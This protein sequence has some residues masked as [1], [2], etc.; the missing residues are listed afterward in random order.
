MAFYSLTPI[1]DLEIVSS[2]DV[3]THYRNETNDPYFHV[4]LSKNLTMGWYEIEVSIKCVKGSIKRSKI[5]FDL[6]EGYE[7]SLSI[8]IPEIK[9]NKITAIV[10]FPAEVKG[11]RLDPTIALSEFVIEKIKITKLSQLGATKKLFVVL[12]NK[13]K[14][15]TLPFL[16]KA[17]TRSGISG[18]REE[19]R[20]ANFFQAYADDNFENLSYEQWLAKEISISRLA[21]ENK[22]I[23]KN[24]SYN[25]PLISIVV[26]TY[27]TP[28]KWLNECIQSVIDQ[29]YK[30]WE[31]C[32]SD[33]ASTNTAVK[34]VLKNY[35]EKDPRIKVFFR[36]T[37]GYISTSTN[38]ALE[39]V[40]GEWVAFLDHDDT[41]TENAL[42]EMVS[43]L[44]EKPDLDVIYSDQD[45][46]KED[47]TYYQPFFKPDWSPVF[48][49]GV[50][51]VGHLLIVKNSVGKK[52]GWFNAKF[53]KVQDYELLLR[54]NEITNR[55]GH[56]PKVLYHWRESRGS[57]AFT[58]DAKGKIEELQELAVNQHL[59]RLKIQGIASQNKFPHRLSLHPTKRKYYD[60]ISIIIP[61]KNCASL[62][63]NCI[64]SILEK[65]IYPNYEIVIIDTGSTEQDAM[66]LLEAFDKQEKVNVYH[67]KEKFNFS[68]VNNFGV[69]KATG[70]YFVFLN[71]DTEVITK[72][73]LD[74]M[75]FFA[76]LKQV[77]AV[78]SLLLFPNK[79]VQHAGIV[80]G[81]RGTADHIMRYFP[82]DSD[83]Y[84]GSLSCSREVSAVTA[85]CLMIKKELFLKVGGFEGSYDSVYQD[86]DLCLKIRSKGYS[87]ILATSSV[88]FHHESVSRGNDYNFIDRM[89]LKDQ[90]ETE[91][92]ADPYYNT[93]FKLDVYGQG[94]NGYEPK[95]KVV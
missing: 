68:R 46:I 76:G 42:F 65:T 13:A 34:A 1:H 78:G 70:D 48:F 49:N 10:A 11:L 71:N 8:P 2:S 79:A 5:Y 38:S 53:D 37:N 18:V 39:F 55:I 56:I 57:I 41:L 95:Y 32:I 20:N 59:K 86:V 62:L 91:L 16:F 3:S 4:N 29:T 82:W 33:D 88:L 77:G 43:L 64:E 74:N 92:L 19:L 66:K 94:Y 51:Y 60:K 12:K 87:I 85:A 47:G 26:S 9:D 61:T 63:K 24:G 30:N 89:L 7:E 23:L 81:F 21:F 50:M 31:L 73:W 52:V 36:K 22:T 84:F 25:E 6:G 17:L 40:T 93:N 28:I 44:Q 27:N 75:I 35:T 83:G 90:W 58:G 69:T 15:N 67:Y 72:G 14:G 45:K 54:I 80:L